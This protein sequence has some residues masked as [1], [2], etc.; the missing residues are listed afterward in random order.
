MIA[1][2]VQTIDEEGRELHPDY[3]IINERSLANIA[4]VLSRDKGV[5]LYAPEGHRTGGSLIKAERGI[6]LLFK[7]HP[8]IKPKTQILLVAQEG[9]ENL[10][11]RNVIHIG[12]PFT[13]HEAVS[14][15]KS[16]KKEINFS[17]DAPLGNLSLVKIGSFLP[18]LYWG[19]YA[20]AI[21][22]YRELNNL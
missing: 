3:K 4:S 6:D 8:S 2:L 18:E 5:I 16:L 19:D 21:K 15:I 11:K 17:E 20:K 9:N 13:Y 10:F 1:S 14:E 7:H 22:Q 12:K